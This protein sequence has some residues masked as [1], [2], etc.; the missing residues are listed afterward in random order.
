LIS[1]AYLASEKVVAVE[2][3]D[4]ALAMMSSNKVFLSVADVDVNARSTFLL[5]VVVVVWE[6]FVGFL[7]LAFF[8]PPSP[9]LLC[10]ALFPSPASLVQLGR[11]TRAHISL[12]LSFSFEFSFFFIKN[13]ERKIR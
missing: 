9:V 2:D 11:G 12:S 10:L 4:D 5:F 8:F 6:D 1:Y 7:R 3:D 13:G